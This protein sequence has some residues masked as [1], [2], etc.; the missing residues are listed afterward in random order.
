VSGVRV[1]VAP[2][3]HYTEANIMNPQLT[4]SGTDALL[5]K[6][7]PIPVLFIVWYRQGKGY[8]WRKAGRYSTHA[9]A[10]AA[11]GGKG[12]WHIAPLH[13]ST[14]AGTD[15]FTDVGTEAIDRPS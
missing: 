12:D 14:L 6:P 2:G 3:Y 15:L 11:T 9:E 1:V 5:A 7:L 13:D 10:M 8:R 4:D